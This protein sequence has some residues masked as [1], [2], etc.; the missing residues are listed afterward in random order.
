MIIPAKSDVSAEDATQS[1]VD[2]DFHEPSLGTPVQHVAI[3]F[4][5]PPFPLP[6]ASNECSSVTIQMDEAGVVAL[7]KV[8]NQVRAKV[9]ALHIDLP[10]SF[11]L[12]DEGASRLLQFAPH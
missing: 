11:C 6:S 3:R 10:V 7:S 9:R 1:P 2:L 5:L 4:R 12:P 8:V